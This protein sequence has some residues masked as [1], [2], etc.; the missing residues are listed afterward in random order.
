MLHN[1]H[2]SQF[3]ALYSFAHAVYTK[4]F[5][6]L[7]S[8][9]KQCSFFFLHIKTPL[10]HI[11]RQTLVNDLPKAYLANTNARQSKGLTVLLLLMLTAA[12]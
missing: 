2:N 11:H 9:T 8:T 10:H 7:I 1:A 5:E 4:H 6:P 12:I 3:S